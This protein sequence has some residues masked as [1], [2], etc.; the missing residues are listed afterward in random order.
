M[1]T[2][3]A[4]G[5]IAALASCGLVLCV[6]TNAHATLTLT[7]ANAAYQDLNSSDLSD[8]QIAADLGITT[9]QLG[10]DL[11]NTDGHTGSLFSSYTL[12][13]NVSQ[14]LPITISYVAGSTPIAATYIYVKDGNSGSYIFNLG[15]TGTDALDWNG[16]ESIYITDLFGKGTGDLSHIEI[17]GSSGTTGT[18][19]GGSVPEPSTIFAAALLALPLGISAF[20]SLRK[21]PVA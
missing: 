19:N 16:T 12:S 18:G 3:K 14:A 21:A 6:A 2:T 17:F 7:T 5:V 13:P 4:T 15:S 11:F 9:A 1:N 20:R 8:S 10:T